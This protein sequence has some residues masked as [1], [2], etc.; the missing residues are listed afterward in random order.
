VLAWADPPGSGQPAD[1]E[2]VAR[3]HRSR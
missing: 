2:E 3:S 1:K